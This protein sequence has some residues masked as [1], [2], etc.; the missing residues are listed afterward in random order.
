MP[1]CPSQPLA[2]TPRFTAGAGVCRRRRRCDTPP[3]DAIS[4]DSV[5]RVAR[6]TDHLAQVAAMYERG[7]EFDVLARFEGH[8]GFDGVIL[9]HPHHNYHLE[10]THERSTEVGGAPTREHLLVFYLPDRGEWERSCAR[11]IAAG[12]VEAAAH[13]PYWDRNGKV[14]EDVDGYGVVLQNS[15]WTA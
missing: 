2:P 9:G 6:P 11:M 14:F 10:F 4:R 15:A 7:L 12:F 5:L 13:N 1:P 3:M 8:E